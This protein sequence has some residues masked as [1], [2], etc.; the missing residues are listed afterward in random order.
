MYNV[1]VGKKLSSVN[2]ES[3][4]N[5]HWTPSLTEERI[6]FNLKILEWITVEQ[7][8]FL[9]S[10]IKHLS[11]KNKKVYIHLPAADGIPLDSIIARRRHRCLNLLLADWKMDKLF[12]SNVLFTYPDSFKVTKQPKEYVPFHS[13]TVHPYNILTFDSDFEKLYD[14][15]LERFKNYSKELLATNLDLSFFENHY[16]NYSILKEFYSNVCQHAMCDNEITEAECYFSVKESFKIQ[17]SSKEHLIHN[18]SERISERP[19]EESYFFKD[20]QG[21]YKNE[22]YV[23]ICFQDFGIGIHNSLKDKYFTQWEKVKNLFNPDHEN[24]NLNT[25]ILEYAFLLFSSKNEFQENL[26]IQN[27]IPRG[28][29]VIKDI[30]KRH[31]GLIIARSG[32]G[33]VVL[34]FSTDENNTHYREADILKDVSFPGT[35]I[36]IILPSVK[37]QHI[38]KSEWY[39]TREK[40]GK[41]HVLRKIS[42][43]SLYTNAINTLISQ[44]IDFT[45]NSKELIQGFFKNLCDELVRIKD[46]NRN[47]VILDFAGIDSGL[48]DIYSKLLYFITFC[49]IMDDESLNL[50]IINVIDIDVI[51]SLMDDTSLINKSKG[52]YSKPI[53]C[54]YP[55]LE[56]SWFI[57]NHQFNAVERKKISENMTS[58]WQF[59]SHKDNFDARVNQIYGNVLRVVTVDGKTYNL[60]IDLPKIEVLLKFCMALQ[61]AE[62]IAEIQNKGLQFHEL[63]D[64][65]KGI[66]YNDINLFSTDPLNE[67][68]FL[69]SNG[70]YQ[71]SFLSFIDKLHKKQYRRFVSINLIL[72]LFYTYINNINHIESINKVLT[73]TISSQLLSKEITEILRYLKA[74]KNSVEVIPLANYYTFLNEEPFN[75]FSGS[76][77]VLIVNDVI[78]T[79]GLSRKLANSLTSKECKIISILTIVDTRE[80]IL[81]IDEHLPILSLARQKMEKTETNPFKSEPILIDPIL[82]APATISRENIDNIIYNPV[83]FTKLFNNDNQYKIGYI[84]ANNKHQLYY[85]DVY[86]LIKEDSQNDYFIL[87]T[88]FE[89]LKKSIRRERESRNITKSKSVE[90]TLREFLR[91]NDID[92]PDV[93]IASYLKKKYSKDLNEFD[94]EIICYP[95]SSSIELLENEQHP[96]FSELNCKNSIEIYPLPRI[97]TNKG[98]RFSFPPNFLN[99]RTKNKNILLLDD[100][101]NTGDTIIQLIDT[102]GYFDVKS[103]TVL[104]LV[105]RIENY[106]IELFN[107]IKNLKARENRIPINIYFCVHFHFP[108]YDKHT[109]PC[110]VELQEIGRFN[111]YFTTKL[112][113]EELPPLIKFYVEQRKKE[114]DHYAM[115]GGP[116]INNEYLKKLDKKELFLFRDYLGSYDSYRLFKEDGLPVVGGKHYLQ[117]I[118]TQIRDKRNFLKVLIILYYEPHLTETIWRMD[119]VSNVVSYIE[120]DLL[121]DDDFISSTF[122]QRLIITSI[123]NLDI[124]LFVKEGF[125]EKLFS[126]FY[127]PKNG[128]E[129]INTDISICQLAYIIS[130]NLCNI[131]EN[132][133]KQFIAKLISLISEKYIEA[134]HTGNKKNYHNFF[135]QIFLRVVNPIKTKLVMQ[136]QDIF[137]RVWIYYYSVLAD[138]NNH[139]YRTDFGKIG[140]LALLSH[141]FSKESP[142]NKEASDFIIRYNQCKEKVQI[143]LTDNL[144]LLFD[145]LIT[146]DFDQFDKTEFVR[147]AQLISNLDSDYYL[148]EFEKAKSSDDYKSLSE[149]IATF[150][151]EII[152]PDS[153]VAKIV[154][155]ADSNVYDIWNKSI[156]PFEA[157]GRCTI[158]ISHST[159]KTLRIKVHPEPLLELFQHIHNNKENYAPDAMGVLEIKLQDELVCMKFWQDAALVERVN[160]RGIN[161]VRKITEI[162]DGVFET[163]SRDPYSFAIK[164]PNLTKSN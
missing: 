162:Y 41:P 97:L 110:N 153:A 45:N 59:N 141:G 142:N 135:K 111:H 155:N 115:T 6:L 14:K 83:D 5:E 145:R 72:K 133:D 107:R 61:E 77:N 80:T 151:N 152:S 18:L 91:T 120:N 86:S 63:L 147:Y 17:S 126:R 15:K 58:A 76:S 48:F 149:K 19:L 9:I 157:K 52:F 108:S 160:G 56:I 131:K 35:S 117:G 122:N 132:T 150:A 134:Q 65:E 75:S 70:L 82:N 88:I 11:K 50:C 119:M 158:L 12:D 93:A 62:I 98:W 105:G 23:E 74:V 130:Y 24:Q 54:I 69:T 84:K 21:K 99:L 20:E 22:G 8:T 46:H 124:K 138:M 10:W 79:G 118:R 28:L 140:E 123:S 32:L 139:V 73:V 68:A 112:R 29:Y 90:S 92:M 33:K 60:R 114:I 43:L 137:G 49:P 100:A 164:F 1:N 104:S 109:F 81:E 47:L 53:P 129:D 116:I 39:V 26:Y 2:F 121:N 128:P 64:T 106:Q 42:L 38:N 125:L 37:E 30:V 13:L 146:A 7:I 85:L 102:M 3:L 25:R 143:N 78:A 159:D 89:D 67:Q 101:S 94:I 154:F 4:I 136:A 161:F 16:L 66:N 113:Q 127:N 96:V 36:T 31:K 44:Y 51:E 163:I 87:K 148:S 57:Q 40:E 95:Y 34:D 144:K 71:T 27:F 156:L 55:N 103:I